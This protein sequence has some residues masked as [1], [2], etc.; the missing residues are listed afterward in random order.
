MN[1]IIA[2]LLGFD[3]GLGAAA[4]AYWLRR[5]LR[6]DTAAKPEQSRTDP[7]DE[8]FANIMRFEIGGAPEE[9]GGGHGD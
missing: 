6:T 7:I 9:F 8:G 2:L 3:L 1:E 4:G 5:S